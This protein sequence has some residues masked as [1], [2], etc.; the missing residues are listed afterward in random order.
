MSVLQDVSQELAA[1]VESAAGSVV[2]VEA[3]RGR[4]GSGL[5]WS[6]GVIV[7]ADH[8]VER[9]EEIRIGLSDGTTVD[10]RLAGRDS[11]TDVAVL[12]ADG[13]QASPA[14]PPATWGPLEGVRAGQLVLAISR[15]GR[16]VRARLGIISAISEKWRAPSGAELEFYVQPDVEVS[17]GFS[18]GAL[19]DVA[20]RVLG[21][22]TTGLLGRTPLAIPRGTLERT[23]TQLL[24]DGRIRRG[25]LGIGSHPVRLPA[26]IRE[27]IGQRAGVIVVGVEPGSPAERSGLLLGDVLVTID[28]APIR[29]PGEVAERL[30]PASVGTSLKLRILRGGVLQDLSVAVGER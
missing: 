12:R 15:P 19:V 3:R 18:G 1:A 9:D 25:F 10:A 16:A 27:Q 23:V 20:G 24:A 29:H 13:P 4:A 26:A 11:A 2:R 5:V 6:P 28:G 21:M 14:A 22:T 17:F 30:G 7:T 8:I